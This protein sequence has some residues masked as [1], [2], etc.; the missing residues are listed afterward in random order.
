MLVGVNCLVVEGESAGV[1][2][3]TMSLVEGL[4]AVDYEN[5]YLL[6]GTEGRLGKVVRPGV[7][8]EEPFLPAGSRLQRLIWEHFVLARRARAR[9][10]KVLHLP[11]H[12]YPA[13]AA[14]CPVVLTVHD[15]AF[16]KHPETFGRG[17]RMYKA[18]LIRRSVRKAARIICDS[19]STRRDLIELLGVSPSKIHRI[20]LAA[21]P[22]YL[23]EV[24]AAER[25]RVLDR[26]ALPPRFLLYVG[27]LEPRKN[28]GRLID[29]YAAL[30]RTVRPVVPLVIVGRPGWGGEALVRR[31]ESLGLDEHVRFAGHVPVDDLP[32]I[33][34]AA[35]LLIYPS[36]YEG[37]GLPVVE[38]MA[39]GTPVITSNRASLPEVAGDAAA[40]V[41]PLSV[42]EI[43]DAM[44]G[45]LSDRSLNAEFRVK[46]RARAR[47]FSW[48]RTARETAQAY[49]AAAEGRG[50]RVA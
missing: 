44:A 8:L 24:S 25:E 14:R 45:L 31:V 28:I 27:T 15:L 20:L 41:D 40:L 43:A 21:H 49:Q 23:R 19:D 16:L 30:V 3:Y 4:S 6:F 12:T 17:R 13:L 18:A 36:I 32:A 11:D 22:R 48:E 37:F 38:A 9:G 7:T 2:S 42:D 26:H 10:V 46:G 29:A 39:S 35:E 50:G 5:E 34:Q 33:Y 47:L 1:A